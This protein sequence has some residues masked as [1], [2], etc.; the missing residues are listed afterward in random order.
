MTQTENTP[1]DGVFF[2]ALCYNIYMKNFIWKS[3]K[4]GVLILLMQLLVDL[5][6][7]LILT[8]IK[9]D[10]ANI[11]TNVIYSLYLPIAIFFTIALGACGFWGIPG[12]YDN[13]FCVINRNVEFFL[14]AII[15]LIIYVIIGSIV[16]GLARII[17]KYLAERKKR[18]SLSKN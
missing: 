8:F 6:I 9:F 13:F 4:W 1:Q 10:N 17:K 12:I 15:I 3:I 16:Y 18:F 14:A 2:C 11:S 7:F 5:T